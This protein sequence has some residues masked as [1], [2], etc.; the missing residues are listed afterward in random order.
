VKTGKT[1]RQVL[2]ER[3]TKHGL[4]RVYP[5]EYRSWKD[6][7]AR[8]RNPNDTNFKDYGGRGIIICSRWDDFALFFADMGIRA[9]GMTL[10]RIKVDGNYSPDNCRWAS[11]QT[12]ANNKRSNHRIVFGDDTRTLQQ[13]S[14]HFGIE[15]SKVR[16]R[17]KQG[18]P[19]HKVFSSEDFRC[20]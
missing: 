19:L 13:W 1:R 4:C 5:R 18:W 20:V 6:M 15:A 12:Q 10:D 7:R 9:A 3:N 2:I 8:C 16:Y 17:L 14:D 11:H